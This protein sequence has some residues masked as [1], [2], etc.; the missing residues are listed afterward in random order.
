MG[1]YPCADSRKV[2]DIRRRHRGIQVFDV[3]VTGRDGGA[4]VDIALVGDFVGVN[5]GDIAQQ[6][7]APDA[8]GGSR[9][10]GIPSHDG[11]VDVGP[12]R[13]MQGEVRD[14]RGIVPGQWLAAGGVQPCQQC[15]EFTI[16]GSSGSAKRTVSPGR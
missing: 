1:A 9:M 2:H 11:G 12:D 4:L 7:H 16:A 14:G 10:R 6:H 5:G 8:F 3:V 13:R 15:D